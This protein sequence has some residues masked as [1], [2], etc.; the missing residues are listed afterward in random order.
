MMRITSI[1][2]HKKGVAMDSETQQQAIL[3]LLRH[4]PKTT[5][6]LRNLGISHPAG[7]IQELRKAGHLINTVL[8][9]NVADGRGGVHHN[10]ARYVLRQEAA[11]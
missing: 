2:I 7:R 10:V 9:D 1:F 4:G 8:G 3:K 5:F 6:E 11:Q